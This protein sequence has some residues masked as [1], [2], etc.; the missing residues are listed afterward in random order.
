MKKYLQIIK[1]TIAENLEYRLNFVLWR[2]RMVIQ[3]LVV[4]FFW[5]AMFANRDTFSGYTSA[6]MLTYITFTLIIRTIVMSS[7][8]FE[9]G[10]QIIH[11]TLSNQLI[12][13]VNIF[14]TLFARDL[15]DKLLNIVFMFSEITLFVLLLRPQLVVQTNP[16]YLISTVLA[17]GIG[18]VLFSF[19]GILIG[20]AG[21][22]AS[23]VWA[24][25]F[26][27]YVLLEF[28]TGMLFPLDIL[29][30]GIS[31]IMERL[32]FAYFIYIP[33][34]IYLGRW[35]IE[36][37]VVSLGIGLLWMSLFW[38]MIRVVW[39]KGLRQYTAVGR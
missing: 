38:W 8:V 22:W 39:T 36:A 5:W 26:L 24:T 32:P 35:P 6:T 25:R 3:L 11:G 30:S 31:S 12:R 13:P 28:F 37:V 20:L 21:F 7:T 2:V 17:V 4:Y 23:D 29:P 19:V 27:F 16:F 15:A 9:L 18:A 14:A 34:K 10:N 1:G 33:L